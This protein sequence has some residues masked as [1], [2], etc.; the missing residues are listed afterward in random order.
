MKIFW[1]GQKI[2][3]TRSL[4]RVSAKP[5][6]QTMSLQEPETG[7]WRQALSARSG[8][9]DSDV[10]YLIGSCNFGRLLLKENAHKHN[11]LELLHSRKCLLQTSCMPFSQFSFRASITESHFPGLQVDLVA[12]LSCIKINISQQ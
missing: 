5:T 1:I 8:I 9:N 3:K 7:I 6:E 2:S 12:S 4:Q 11:S 10:H